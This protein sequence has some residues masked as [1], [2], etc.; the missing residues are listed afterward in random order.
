M[1]IEAPHS[2]NADLPWHPGPMG[3]N[4]SCRSARPFSGPH[5]PPQVLRFYELYGT[6]YLSI[7]TQLLGLPSRSMNQAHSCACEATTWPDAVLLTVGRQSVQ[8]AA[9]GIGPH[10]TNDKPE[11]LFCH[12]RSRLLE[13]NRLQST[14]YGT[15]P[16]PGVRVMAACA[17]PPALASNLR[18]PARPDRPL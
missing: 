11:N 14:A 13:H 3:H 7:Q 12:Q 4:T 5:T 17:E 18:D 6:E 15:I 8:S 1:R 2:K 10:T 9:H 16:P